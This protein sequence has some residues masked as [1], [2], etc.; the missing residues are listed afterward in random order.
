MNV[1][2]R[3]I[4]A[5]IGLVVA[6]VIVLTACT[7]VQHQSAPTAP[8]AP[9]GSPTGSA[10][11]RPVLDDLVLG[12][13]GLGPLHVGSAV[14]VAA[15][16]TAVVSWN[17][18]A[19]VSTDLGITVTD[20]RAGVWQA[21][22]PDIQQPDGNV[23][24]FIVVTS[25]GG[26]TSPISAIRVWGGG[27]HTAKGIHVGSTRADVLAAYGSSAKTVHG[28]LSDVFILT[29]PTGSLSIEVA[30]QYSDGG[31]NYWPDDQVDTVLWMATTAP[32]IDPGPIAG[33]DGGS[34]ACPDGS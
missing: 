22:Y 25:D 31:S 27:I 20:P 34:S 15:E 16:G 23:A 33:T 32:A 10:A 3:R 7:P 4:A 29:G 6:A 24:P 9:T 28:G 14:P 26:R 30:T 21:R 8:G 17:A 13:S 19:C 11:A 2:H 5:P 18:T 12:P 1:I